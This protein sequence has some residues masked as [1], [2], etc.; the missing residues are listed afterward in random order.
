MKNEIEIYIYI[1]RYLNN[2]LTLLNFISFIDSIASKMGRIFENVVSVTIKAKLKNDF[3]KKT[4]TLNTYI[5]RKNMSTAL[6][7]FLI[8]WRPEA[9]VCPSET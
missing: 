2:Y 6:L 3:S 8:S 5:S 9:F 7:L 4:L 1:N